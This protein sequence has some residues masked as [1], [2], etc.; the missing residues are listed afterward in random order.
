MMSWCDER[1]CAMLRGKI[2]KKYLKSLKKHER[3]R[4]FVLNLG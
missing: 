3:K 1:E 2:S 4:K